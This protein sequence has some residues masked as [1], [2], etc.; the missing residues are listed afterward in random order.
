VCG[1]RVRIEDQPGAMDDAKAGH[2]CGMPCGC[3]S[4]AVH[5]SSTACP[6]DT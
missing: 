1:S 2:V 3:W 6:G 5:E 4:P